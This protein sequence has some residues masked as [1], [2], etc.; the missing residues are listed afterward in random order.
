MHIYINVYLDFFL[1]CNGVPIFSSNSGFPV[2]TN[3]HLFTMLITI[4]RKAS[5]VI[6]TFSCCE[7]KLTMGYFFL[8]MEFVSI[9]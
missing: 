3:G 1:S 6:A 7:G 5:Q 4:Q 2:N 9:W 8:M